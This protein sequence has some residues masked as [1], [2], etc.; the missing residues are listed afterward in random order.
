MS[1]N[2]SLPT[3]ESI[4]IDVL[5]RIASF[6]Y[7]MDIVRLRQVSKFLREV[8]EGRP[9]WSNAYRTTTLPRHPGPFPHQ[10]T[11]MLKESLIESAKLARGWAPHKLPQRL[12][13]PSSLKKAI[14]GTKSYWGDD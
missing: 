12:G 5:Y 3:L 14:A 1:S 11:E 10:S 4:P 2:H 8:I 6:I 13:V 7:V 9:I